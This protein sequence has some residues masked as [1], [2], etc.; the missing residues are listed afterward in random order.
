M[1]TPETPEDSEALSKSLGKR[2]VGREFIAGSTESP[3]GNSPG[4]SEKKQK[5][6][7]VSDIV[8][9]VSEDVQNINLSDSNDPHKERGYL[10]EF[11]LRDRSSC[12]IAGN[13]QKKD[14]FDGNSEEND[15]NMDTLE[16]E[17]RDT[18]ERSSVKSCD[19]RQRNM[20]EHGASSISEAPTL[21]PCIKE[22][23]SQD[24]NS[25]EKDLYLKGIEI[26][27]KNRYFSFLFIIQAK[28]ILDHVP[29]S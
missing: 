9:L 16:D 14:K 18:D 2:K 28:I 22:R 21:K 20:M 10:P 19:S 12:E 27:G 23:S 7:P 11:R 6:V 17:M 24:W 26:F 29:Y 15:D 3:P 13:A 5:K 25:I 4:Y 8:S 1:S